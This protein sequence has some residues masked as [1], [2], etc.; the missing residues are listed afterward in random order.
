MTRWVVDALAVWR[1]TRLVAVDGITSP[2]RERITEWAEAQPESTLREKVAELVGCPHCVS[3][4]TALGLV[5][6]VR[7]QPWW[8]RMADAL[9]LAAVSS[10][11][12]D[13]RDALD[14]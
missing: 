1:L 6:V 2:I 9:A 11:I 10:L 4:W 3:V 12:A 8:P 7:R 5:F 13:G 14:V